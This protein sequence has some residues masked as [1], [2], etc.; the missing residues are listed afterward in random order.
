MP[1]FFHELRQNRIALIIWT[2]ILSF[3]LAVSVLIY[4]EMSS[5]LG[6]LSG[7]FSDMGSFSEAFGMIYRLIITPKIFA[8]TLCRL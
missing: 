8:S 5:Q 6:E 7:M 4:P 2:A 3:L 1:L